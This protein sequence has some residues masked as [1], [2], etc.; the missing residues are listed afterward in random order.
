MSSGSNK[1]ST[2]IS[3]LMV[4]V[5]EKNCFVDR[6]VYSVNIAGSSTYDQ[7]YGMPL[8]DGFAI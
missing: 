7:T 4:W 1:T 8:S 6:L 2:L 5:S 3:I